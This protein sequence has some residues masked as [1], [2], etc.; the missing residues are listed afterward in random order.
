VCLVAGAVQH[1]HVVPGQPLAAVQE[2]GL[3][4]LDGEQV[5]RLLD[6]D[7]EVRSLGVGLER[8]GGDHRAGQVQALKQRL[9]AGHLAGGAVD[10][11]LGQHPAGGVLH[12]GQQ[13]DLPA[14]A[15]RAAQRLAVHRDRPSPLVRMVTV[16]QP[17]AN[18]PG[19]RLGIQ[20]R[21][22]P[23]DG[24][25]AGHHPVGG[26]VPAGAKRL[27]DRLRGIRGPLGDR[28][29]GPCAGQH[30]GSGHGQDRDQRVTAA[31][32]GAWVGDGRQVGQQV[33]GL[34][35]LQRDGI[36]KLGEGRW[37]RG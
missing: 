2:G 21:Q 18:H 6:G 4:G 34:G 25:L 23:A 33:T 32:L 24:G 10:L 1:R 27:A 9:E 37:D 30:R 11:A 20:T 29:H 13:V 3:V 17:R 7:Q 16:G 31:T 12:G 14:A 22:G 5:V 28:G 35:H 19:Q 36:G 15:T 8:V 26:G